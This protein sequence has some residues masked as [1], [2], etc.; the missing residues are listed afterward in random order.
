MNKLTQAEEAKKFIKKNKKLLIEK[1]ANK[2]RFLSVNYPFSIFMAGSPGAGK[3]E[4]SKAL[5]RLFSKFKP[6]TKIVQIDADEIKEI[7]PQYNGHNSNVVQGASSLGV[8]KLYDYVLKNRQ[9]VILDGTF[10]NY[11]ISKK[12]IERSIN[13]NREVAI[14]YIHQD[15][16]IAWEHTKKREKLEG[17]YVPKNTFIESYFL[18]KD[19]AN[20][21]KNMF[22]NKVYLYLIDKHYQHR[23]ETSYQNVSNI[24]Y[25]IKFKYNKKQLK[26]KLCQ[27]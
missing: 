1:F 25:Y 11:N 3:T 16:I 17:R 6:A 7:I 13:K 4:T 19:N 18:A 22:K 2:K 8:E 14:F 9:N 20:K 24:D 26:D 15:P 23:T 5:I 27:K 21:I 10:A 12:N